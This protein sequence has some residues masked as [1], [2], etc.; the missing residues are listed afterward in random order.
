MQSGRS[1]LPELAWSGIN[2]PPS[3]QGLFRAAKAVTVPT[4]RL[5]IV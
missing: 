2:E 1:S 4:G 5:S 3:V